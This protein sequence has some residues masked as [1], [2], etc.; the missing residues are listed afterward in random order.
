MSGTSLDGI[1]VALC[2][3]S[4]RHTFD[5]MNFRTVSYPDEW[6]N[7][8]QSAHSLSAL[9]LRLLEIEY[10]KFTA[11]IVLELLK[12]TAQTVDF[13]ACHGHTIFHQ[14]ENNLTYQMLDGSILATLSGIT[15]VWDFRSGDMALGGQGAPLVPIGDALLFGEYE[16]CLNLG[17]FANMSYEKAG[18]RIAYDISPA[19]LLLNE[20]ANREGL[21]YDKNGDLARSG[22]IVQPLLKKLNSLEFYATPPPK[23]LGREWLEEKINPFIK[24]GS[25][26]DL[27]ATAVVHISDQVSYALNQSAASGKVLVT[28]GGA[29]N[30][31]LMECISRKSHLKIEIPSAEIIDAKE[32][33]VFALLGKLRLENK[34]NILS[35]VTGAS[36]DS[37]GG[38]VHV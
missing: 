35:S 5:L 25:T 20:L 12:E 11:H 6:K 27:L 19:N 4:D 1:D 21:D 33:I 14:P 28:G 22:K 9:N 30:T 23:S 15:T 37:C 7:K 8:L 13:I 18:K 3:F 31:Y 36:R 16:A 32:A 38:A 2:K 10:S 24:N 17:G 29:H 26:N 34:I